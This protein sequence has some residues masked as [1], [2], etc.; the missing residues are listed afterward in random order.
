MLYWYVCQCSGQRALVLQGLWETIRCWADVRCFEGRQDAQKALCGLRFRWE[1][2]PRDDAV[3]ISL[4]FALLENPMCILSCQLIYIYIDVWK[5]PGAQASRNRTSRWLSQPSSPTQPVELE[6]LTVLKDAKSLE[7]AYV[8]PCSSFLTVCSENPDV[9]VWSSRSF[10]M[11]LVSVSDVATHQVPSISGPWRSS[12][13]LRC[14]RWD[15][16]F[17]PPNA[18]WVSTKWA[19]QFCQNPTSMKHK[20]RRQRTHRGP[21]CDSVRRAMRVDGWP[22][23]FK[24][25]TPQ[26]WG[27]L[28]NS[29]A[30]ICFFL[31]CLL[32]FWV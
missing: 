31:A 2:N 19:Q 24:Q 6:L 22:D 12:R 18:D 9:H 16:D 26:Q 14:G 20:L 7:I 13:D 5:L 32:P 29:G 17:W 11:I 1:R 10:W 23:V 28:A 4:Y 21:N 8:L 30:A 27:L 15:Q 25:V 3:T